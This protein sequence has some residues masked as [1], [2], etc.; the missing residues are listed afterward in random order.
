MSADPPPRQS[1]RLDSPSFFSSHLPVS[2]ISLFASRRALRGITL[3][4]LGLG[5]ATLA[6]AQTATTTPAQPIVLDPIVVTGTRS[7]SLARSVPASVDSVDLGAIAPGQQNINASEVLVRVPGLVVQ[8]RQNYAQDLQISSRGFGSRAAFGVRGIKLITDGIPAS[9]PD[10]QGQATFNLDTAD[11]IDVLRGPLSTI[12]GSNAGGVIEVFSRDGQGPPRVTTEISGG[13]DGLRKYRIGAE[14][15][16][17]GVGFLFDASRMSTDGYREHSA[18]T[19]QQQFGKINLKPDADSRLAITVSG[20]H[21]RDTQ[22]PLG[23][24]WEQ[25]R[26]NPRGVAPVALQYNTRKSI[27]NQQ[28]GVNYERQ[29]GSGSSIQLNVYG[30]NRTVGQY[31]AIPPSAQASP[32]HAGGVVDFDRDFQGVGLRWLQTVS[33]APG[34]L[35]IVAGLDYDRARDDRTG[36]ENFIGSTLGVRGRLRRDEVDTVTSLD[37]YAQAN[38]TLGAW[39]LQAGVRHNTVRIDVD[40]KFL[41]N[42]DDSGQRRFSKTTPSAG[43]MYAV[44]PDVNVYVSAGKGFET[45]TQAELAYS[46]NGGGF[47]SGLSPSTSTQYE[48]GVKARIAERARLNAAVFDIRTENELVVASASGGR[49]SYRNAART[50]RRGVELSLDT[51]FARDWS[52]LVSLT[53][54]DAYYDGSA[55]TGIAS[56]NQLPGVP[57]T[58]LYSE[59]AWQPRPWVSTAI[60][61]V[62]RSK[63]YVEDT[64]TAQAA[65]GYGVVNWRT[66]FEQTAG[67]WTFRQ[68]L[69]LDNLFGKR[70]I[71]S[72]IV[73]D[74]NGRYYEPASG[75]TW[76]AGV[77]AQY[78]F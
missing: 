71:G 77:S 27:D 31:L 26:T 23:L 14:G 72:V 38:W 54:L 66:R 64:N 55:G 39:T 2:R 28:V 19:R 70:Y 36:Y 4:G 34:K 46:A 75:L 16:Y 44:N 67:P 76:F 33:Q 15:E 40:D 18:A 61:G 57:M 11:R 20:L 78:A 51:A 22:D 48:A 6:H 21:Q 29:L 43:L 59:I 45:P 62:L 32:R 68:T 37:P 69:R 8:N 42:G 17:Q 47:N 5:A 60:E 58:T 7:P 73:G 10:G 63:V 65:P 9:T 74:G 52:S 50:K 49:T 53:Y 25:A 30:G 24:T 13:S 56:G 12:Y 3:A 1:A 35:D 41:S